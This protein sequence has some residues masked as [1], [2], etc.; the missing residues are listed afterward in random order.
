M[1]ILSLNANTVYYLGVIPTSEL[2]I[3]EVIKFSTKRFGAYTAIAS[4]PTTEGEVRHQNQLEIQVNETDYLYGLWRSNCESS[5][6]NN[7][8]SIFNYFSTRTIHI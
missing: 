5:D 7:D 4:E 8:D 3:S 2:T 1:Q 6:N